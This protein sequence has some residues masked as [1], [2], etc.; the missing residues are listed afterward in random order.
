MFTRLSALICAALLCVAALPAQAATNP[1]YASIIMDADTGMIL[2]Q[3]H[4]D[5]SLHPASLAKMM[6]LALTFDALAD[7]RLHMRDRV[8]MSKHAASMIPSKLGL[9]PGQTLSVEDAIY[10]LVTKSANDVAVA[11]GEKLGGTES[12]FAVMMT[13]KAHALG[14]TRTTF[15]NA[16][17]LHNP[18]QVTTAR[19]MA[20]LARYLIKRYPQYYTYFSTRE[21]SY[22][23]A[24]FHNHNRLMDRY[25]GMDGLKTGFIGQSGFNLVAS[26]VRDNHRLIGVVF[27]GRTAASRDA[28][29]AQ[30]LDDGFKQVVDIRVAAAPVPARKPDSIAQLA[31]AY[32]STDPATGDDVSAADE[33]AEEARFAALNPIMQNRTFSNLIGEGDSDPAVSRRLETGLKAIAAVRG[34]QRHGDTTGVQI[35][36]LGSAATAPAARPRP[37]AIQIGAFESRARTDVALRAAMAKLPAELAQGAPFIAP[38][39]TGDSWLFRARLG[40][41]SKEQAMA[42]CKVL[43]DCLPVAPQAY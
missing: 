43:K 17:G 12:Q 26:A 6:T 19:D 40:G 37:W 36:S 8:T 35:A 21:F 16:S 3:S 24:S 27:G 33:A 23:G 11:M 7:G 34:E 31:A 10:A 39:K 25:K 15:R 13:N 38:L 9:N 42:A 22:R 5:K 2:H 18:Q 14:M 41:Y 28:H 20:K 4:A 30:L 32:N 1:R 29:M